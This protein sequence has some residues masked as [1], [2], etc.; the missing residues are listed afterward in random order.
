MQYTAH[1]KWPNNTSTFDVKTYD[2]THQIKVGGGLEMTASSAP[3]FA[4][5]KE[6]PNPEELFTSSIASCFSLSL[7]YLIAMKGF[8]MKDYQC[9][10]IGT[11]AKNAEGKM[12]MTE[13]V[14]KPTVTFAEDKAP[15]AN[16]LNELFKKAHDTCFISSS[17]KTVVRIEA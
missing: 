16:T 11:L 5:K 3:E 13:V 7:F 10:A 4:G 6:L 14:L 17:V 8:V 9:E 2:R 1:I 15:D 12:A